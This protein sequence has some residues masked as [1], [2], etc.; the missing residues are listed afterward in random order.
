[1]GQHEE[2]INGKIEAGIFKSLSQQAYRKFPAVNHSLLRI[3]HEGKSPAH[4]REHFLYPPEQET[5]LL[6]GEA[7]HVKMCEPEEFSKHFEVAQECNGTLQKRRADGSISCSKL[8]VGI[9]AEGKQYCSNHWNIFVGRDYPSEKKILPPSAMRM[10]DGMVETLGRD[11]LVTGLMQSIPPENREVSVVA[12]HPYYKVNGEPL[13]MKARFDAMLSLNCK[14]NIPVKN[15]DLN[16]LIDFKTTRSASGKDFPWTVKK[17]HYDKQ[18]AHYLSVANQAFKKFGYKFENFIII[19]VEKER[20]YV[21]QTFRVRD[22]QIETSNVFVEEALE[23]YR[24]CLEDKF[25]PG[26]SPGQL[27]TLGTSSEEI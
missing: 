3:L 25:W 18:A 20:P 15:G 27:I 22:E 12:D 11:S 21:H 10:I 17:Y 14:G 6:Q 5:S 13:K 7:F 23:V 16:T 8:G 4:L 2:I 19:A 1:M 26:Y 24:S 9:N